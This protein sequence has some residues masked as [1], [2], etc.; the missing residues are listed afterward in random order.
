[1]KDERMSLELRRKLLHSFF[2]LVM[3]FI[4]FY[5]KRR[6]L[7]AFL[8]VLLLFGSIMILWRLQGNRIPIADWFEETFERKNVKFPGYG[9]FWYV[10]GTLLLVLSLGEAN[11]IAAAI[12]TLAIGDSAAT[13]FGLKGVHILPHNKRKTIEGSLAFLVFSLPSCLFVGWIGIP[14]S[15]ITAI[16]ESL[17]VPFDD[18]LMIP[19]ISVLFFVI[20]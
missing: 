19:I 8:S 13:I 3:I 16:A 11:E 9:A 18:N 14:L 7:I 12:L 15:V 10:V 6:I 2:G 1:M 4:F 5:F 20:I 17:P